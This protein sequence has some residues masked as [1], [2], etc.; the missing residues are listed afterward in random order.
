MKRAL[1]ALA[2]FFGC[3]LVAQAAEPG[4]LTT[5]HA[6][7]SLSK[8]DAAMGLPVAFEATVTYYIKTD[9]DLFVQEGGEAIYVE[10][11]PN[12]NVVPGDRVLVRGKTRDSYRTDVLG[13]SVTRLQAGTLPTPTA[14]DFAQ[15]IRGEVDS[16]RVTV[17]GS[18]RS[19]DTVSYGNLPQLDL[20]LLMEGG[21]IDA[22]VIGT[23]ADKPRDMLELPRESSTPRT[24]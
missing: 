4:T 16:M 19:L 5:L 20:K 12:L 18:V 17:R 23:A 10:A 22:T 6:I 1:P 9:I 15:L 8:A 11:K 3:A 24:S 7:H 13:D 14:A 2:I 21:D